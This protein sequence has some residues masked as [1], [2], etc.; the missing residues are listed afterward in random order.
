MRSIVCLLLMWIGFLHGA[1]LTSLTS[2][3]VTI[4]D[5]SITVTKEVFQSAYPCSAP[6]VLAFL[7]LHENENTSVTAVRSYLYSHGGSLVKF[8]VGHSRLISFSMGKNKY[9]VDPNRIFTPEGISATLAQYS[10]YTTE[11][12]TEVEKLASFVLDVY[13]FNSQTTVMALHNNAGSYG[14]Q[15]YL[16]GGAY[17]KDAEK[18]NIVNGTNPSNFFYVVEP[19]FYDALSA[20]GYNIVLQNNAT[21]QNDGSLSY[22][23]G[24]QG[25]QYVNFE[26][27]AEYTAIGQQVVIQLDMIYASADVIA[28]QHVKSK[29]SVL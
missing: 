4:G 7:N 5:T 21:V 2:H 29:K 12:A 1:V 22:F 24:L 10:K 17:E 18:V 23:A 3:Q 11:A 25:K 15:S 16:P 8:N 19:Y 9:S 26:A 27:I 6:P 14:A 13:D 28:A 20:R